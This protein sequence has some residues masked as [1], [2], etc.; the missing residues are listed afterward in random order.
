MVGVE[1]TPCS[2]EKLAPPLRHIPISKSGRTDLN[3]WPPTPEAGVLAKL[4]Y[5]PKMDTKGIEPLISVCR[6][7]VFPIELRAHKW[8]VR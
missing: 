7:D 8:R 4:N 5:T 6:T 3:R 2:Y 1:P